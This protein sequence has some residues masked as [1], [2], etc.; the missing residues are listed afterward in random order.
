M[1]EDIPVSIAYYSIEKNDVL[2]A[3]LGTID[4][5]LLV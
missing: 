2:P 3:G 1:V 5:L 4:N